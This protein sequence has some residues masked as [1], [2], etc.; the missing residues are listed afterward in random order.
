MSSSRRV[1][2]KSDAVASGLR[3]AAGGVALGLAV[4]LPLS[5]VMGDFLFGIE[6]T[7]PRVYT[8]IAV[9]VGLASVATAYVPARRAAS[10]DPVSVLNS[11]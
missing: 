10:V 4:A 8:A 6:A 11:D 7:D 1:I 2:G 5:R 9:S 3:L